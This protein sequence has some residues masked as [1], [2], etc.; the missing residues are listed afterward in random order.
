MKS[1]SYPKT[2]LHGAAATLGLL[3]AATL[4]PGAQAAD[5][6]LLDILLANGAITT[7]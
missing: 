7:A 5:K 1:R 3:V 6:E 2:R 4:A